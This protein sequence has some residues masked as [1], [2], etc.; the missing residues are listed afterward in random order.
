MNIIINKLKSSGYS[1]VTSR[2]SDEI[3]QLGT[4]TGK[5]PVIF[6]DSKLAYRY[7]VENVFQGYTMFRILYVSKTPKITPEVTS[8]LNSISLKLYSPVTMENLIRDLKE[9]FEEGNENGLD[10]QFS[11]EQN[12]DKK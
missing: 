5:V 6:F 1:C 3:D 9:Y 8:K 12:L 4:L 11:V 7:F 2:K 10:I